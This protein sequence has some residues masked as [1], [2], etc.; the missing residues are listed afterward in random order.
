MP[1]ALDSRIVLPAAVGAVIVQVPA[2][3]LA[4]ALLLSG[5]GD[6]GPEAF[7]LAFL[8]LPSAAGIVWVW[9]FAVWREP[10][11]WPDI[12]FA[13][14]SGRWLWEAVAVGLLSVLAIMLITEMAAPWFGEPK[15]PPLP[16]PAEQALT[17]P[18]Y[19]LVLVLG[20]A[21]IGPLMEEMVFRGLLFGWLRQRFNWWLAGAAAALAH[22]LLHFDPGALPGLFVF[23]LFLAWLYERAESLWVPAIVHGTHNFVV[24]QLG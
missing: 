10:G 17:R 2:A 21:V 14:V 4:G 18:L 15:G 6:P 9:F 8:L 5:D 20:G 1:P 7:L 19:L 3:R 16:L 24:L 11:G 12:G 22:A 13:K 23:F